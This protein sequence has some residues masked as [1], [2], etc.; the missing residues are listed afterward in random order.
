M[1][2]QVPGEKCALHVVFTQTKS[3]FCIICIFVLYVE[4][5]EDV[6]R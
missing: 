4:L 5:L 2:L 6:G 3:L 1:E